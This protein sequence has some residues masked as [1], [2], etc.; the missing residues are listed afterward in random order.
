MS[1][2]QAAQRFRHPPIAHFAAALMTVTHLETYFGRG[3]DTGD[4][5]EVARRTVANWLREVIRDDLDGDQ[6]WDE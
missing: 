6:F 5:L 2:G 3:G 4:C 1:R